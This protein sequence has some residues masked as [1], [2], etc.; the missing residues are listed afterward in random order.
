MKTWM[1]TP[2]CLTTCVVNVCPFFMRKVVLRSMNS[3]TTSAVCKPIDKGVMSKSSKSCTCEDPSPRDCSLHSCTRAR[4]A[5]SPVG[6]QW[7]TSL[8][9]RRR[10]CRCRSS[11]CHRG[12]VCCCC[13]CGACSGKMKHDVQDVCVAFFSSRLPFL[14]FSPCDPSCLARFLRGS[15]GCSPHFST[16]SRRP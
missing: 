13:C 7:S 11:C 15:R 4:P 12:R 6:L 1:R 8:K 10:D 16:V 5:F 9:P 14:R 2:G 3:I